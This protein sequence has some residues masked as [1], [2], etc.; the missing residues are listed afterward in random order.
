MAAGTVH[1]VVCTRCA[2]TVVALGTAGGLRLARNEARDH[3][4]QQGHASTIY[5]ASE[6]ETV[7]PPADADAQARERGRAPHWPRPE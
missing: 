1:L 7:A 6:L 5:L 3:T 2:R 4:L